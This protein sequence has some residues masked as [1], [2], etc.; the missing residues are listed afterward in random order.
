LKFTK[1]QL[2]AIK[3]ID[4]NRPIAWAAWQVVSDSPMPMHIR[5]NGLEVNGWRSTPFYWPVIVAQLN[6]RTAI[7]ARVTTP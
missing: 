4:G 5:Q 7:F 3:R 6:L 2:A 1:Q